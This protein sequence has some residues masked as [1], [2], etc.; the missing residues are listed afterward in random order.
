MGKATSEAAQVG[1]PG[2]KVRM[3]SAAPGS[4]SVSPLVGFGF[5]VQQATTISQ[6]LHKWTGPTPLAY[7]ST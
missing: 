2:R 4:R 5:T 1:P 3:N 7:A 6:E